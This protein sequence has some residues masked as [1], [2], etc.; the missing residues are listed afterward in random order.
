MVPAVG[1]DTAILPVLNGMAHLDA[2][3]ARFGP[4]R[5]LGGCC[6][7]AVTVTSEGAIRHIR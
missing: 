2:L 3:D 4:G 5:V 6:A 1:A 7:I